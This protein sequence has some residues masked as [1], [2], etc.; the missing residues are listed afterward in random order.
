MAKRDAALSN[1]VTSVYVRAM[2]R[3]A[4]PLSTL[5]AHVRAHA[6]N[7]PGVYRMIGPAGQTLYVGKSVHVRTRLLSYFRARPGEKAWRL[8]RDTTRII[9]D[10]IP[11]EFGAL[12]R[13]LRLIQ[14]HTPAYN[15]RHKGPRSV[16]FIKITA[17]LAPRLAVVRRPVE[18]RSEYFGPLPRS[19]RLR[20]AVTD[21]AHLL[22]IR[23]CPSSTPMH[24]ADQLDVFGSAGGGLGAFGRA[25]KCI[26]AELGGCSAPCAGHVSAADYRRQIDRARAFFGGREDGVLEPLHAAMHEAAAAARFEYAAVLRD[27]LDRLEWLRDHVALFEHEI[28]S[29]NFVYRPRPRLG[30]GRLYV[31][32]QGR[33]CDHLWWPTTNEQRRRARQRIRAHFTSTAPDPSRWT[34]SAAAEALFVARW[35]RLHPDEHRRTRAP[36]WF[37]ATRRPSAGSSRTRRGARAERRAASC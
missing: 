6:E 1:P 31:V 33:V 10:H 18:D 24:F 20:E 5:R 37:R 34:S 27:R 21:L 26:R 8:M 22:G 29:L 35:F 3:S 17:D 30:R 32:R 14:R 28:Q 2:H 9:W 12:L 7:R 25:P 23:D 4:I 16:A 13:E 36:E 15:V 11:D 19:T